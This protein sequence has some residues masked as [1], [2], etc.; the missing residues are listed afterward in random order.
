MD[1]RFFQLL[2]IGCLFAICASPLFAPKAYFWINDRGET[3]QEYPDICRWNEQTTFV[4]WQ[5][6][7]AADYDIWG[8]AFDKEGGKL[9]INICIHR[10]KREAD[11][12]FPSIA[13]KKDR[14]YAIVVWQHYD[15]ESS[16]WDICGQL[17]S[18]KG[19][20]IGE[21]FVV[22]ADHEY[23]QQYPA[24]AFSNA[25]LFTVCWQDDRK[26]SDYAWDIY[27]RTFKTNGESTPVPISADYLVNN[28]QKFDQLFPDVSFVTPPGKLRAPILMCYTW[29]DNSRGTWDVSLRRWET[30]GNVVQP[31]DSR[32]TL[33]IDLEYYDK[34][35]SMRPAIGSD[36]NG[37]M[38]VSWEDD[39]TRRAFTVYFQIIRGED[40][41]FV[42]YNRPV[43]VGAVTWTQI[44]ADVMSRYDGDATVV[45]H[46]DR[47]LHWDIFAQ[48]FDIKAQEESNYNGSNWPV[49]EESGDCDQIYPAVDRDD[50]AEAMHSI[51]WMDNRRPVGQWDIY[52]RIMKDNGE[53]A[54]DDIEVSRLFGAE[55]EYDDDEDYNLPDTE[56]WNEDPF[57]HPTVRTE[58][59]QAVID[60]IKENDIDGYWTIFE[61]DTFPERKQKS[62]ASIDTFDV[63]FVD[64]GWRFGPSFEGQMTTGEQDE[65]VDYL[66][67]LDTDPGRVVIIGNDFGYDY[68]SSGLYKH[69][70]IKYE[71][72]GN[73]W[74]TGNVQTLHG[75]EG[76]FTEG[77]KMNY[78]YL[79]TCD[80][81]V[82]NISMAGAAPI[83]EAENPHTKLFFFGGSAYSFAWKADPD[84][85]VHLSFSLSGISSDNHPNTSIEF[86]RRMMA[87]LDQR[88]APEPVTTLRADQISTVDEGEIRL[89]WKAPKNQNVPPSSPD[90]A[91]GYNLKFTYWEDVP[92]HYGKMTDDPEFNAANT[93]YQEWTPET[94]EDPEEKILRGLPPGTPLIFAIKGYDSYSGETRNATL[95]DEPMETVT[96]DLITP[97]TIYVGNDGSGGG[98]VR[99]FL[100]NEIMDKR[101]GNSPGNGE[102]TLFF[103]WDATTLYIGYA[104]HSWQSSG[105]LLVYFDVTTGG[106]GYTYPLNG[107]TDICKLPDDCQADYCFIVQHSASRGLY[108][109]NG[110]SWGLTAYGG[111]FSNDNVVNGYQ[112]TEFS[113]PF[114]NIGYNPVDPFKFLVCCQNESNNNNWNAFPAENLIGAKGQ[115]LNYY[116]YFDALGSGMSPGDD[117]I[118]LNIELSAFNATCRMEGIELEWRTESEEDIYQWAVEKK[119]GDEFREIGRLDASGN[120]QGPT[121]YTFMDRDVEYGHSYTYKLLYISNLGKKRECG[122]MTVLFAPSQ[123]KNPHLYPISPN[124]VR[125]DANASFIIPQK[126]VASLKVYDITG[127]IIQT[128]FEEEKEPGLYTVNVTFKKCA[129]GIY[130]IEFQCDGERT[131]RKVTVL[132]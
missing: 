103:T 12:V 111:N 94:G 102:D 5:D 3:K 24:V 60:M 42:G 97:H 25:E 107:A 40:L 108:H 65:I 75:Q 79:D 114:A 27:A 112:Y 48:R 54:S 9:G 92:P 20:Y 17:I 101:T 91:S 85:T 93:Y 89:T 76:W 30:D 23:N 120:P 122:T 66:D 117:V 19:E 35:A 33:V 34:C 100:G 115:D 96:G 51:T 123:L 67:T 129:Q 110:S 47:N 28:Q 57:T 53:P 8:Q 68:G 119:E 113:I 59:A 78:R 38:I 82:D 7:R 6:A 18:D 77:M 41:S 90:A 84:K 63:V 104:R 121:E 71:L 105:D 31:Y 83:F 55:T 50:A 99:D 56:P 29:Q 87:W 16:T 124:P 86:V 26:Y 95:G 98:Y 39:R 15:K 128:V 46:D 13:C 80:N 118:T 11:Q 43:T 130:F 126:A 22:N 131:L 81:Y 36:E 116:Y 2:I 10:D 61:A 52:Y 127:R 4:V 44:R 64:L 37:N 62:R 125:T 69:F 73:I 49:N 132:R 72:D 45:W 109:Y 21:M 1:K 106:A 32:D 88:V 14:P 74:T 58:A 70:K